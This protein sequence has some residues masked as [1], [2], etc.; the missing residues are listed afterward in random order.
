MKITV[1]LE[2]VKEIVEKELYRRG[3][4]IKSKS[5]DVTSHVEG[6]YD[7]SRSVV[8]GISFEIE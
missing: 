4:P 8:D 2:E 1:T 5:G 3:L 7:D 6:M